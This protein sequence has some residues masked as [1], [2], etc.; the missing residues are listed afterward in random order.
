MSHKRSLWTSSTSDA[1]HFTLKCDKEEKRKRKHSRW[2]A[3]LIALH[4]N[5]ATMH[6]VNW[7]LIKIEIV[8]R[9][10]WALLTALNELYSVFLEELCEKLS[11]RVSENNYCQPSE[12]LVMEKQ[13]CES[14]LQ[15][16]IDTKDILPARAEYSCLLPS[17][18]QSHYNTQQVHQCRVGTCSNLHPTEQIQPTAL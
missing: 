7:L 2:S 9:L 6:S 16:H 8:K 18:F 5:Y 12:H 4:R 15:K 14:P 1:E 11:L 17:F 13:N 3:E 10:R